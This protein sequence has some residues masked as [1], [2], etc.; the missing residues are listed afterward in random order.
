MRSRQDN[1]DPSREIFREKSGPEAFD[2][3]VGKTHLVEASTT[4][5]EY[6]LLSVWVSTLG[7]HFNVD[8]VRGVSF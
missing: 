3:R 1:R 5:N 2:L 4:R 8:L 7:S 6:T